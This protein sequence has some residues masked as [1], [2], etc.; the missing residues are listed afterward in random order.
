M[1]SIG[2]SNSIRENQ[3][4]LAINS[5]NLIIKREMKGCL[6]LNETKIITFITKSVIFSIKYCTFP[7][8]KYLINPNNFIKRN[9]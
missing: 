1:F 2:L 5:L 3:K 7:G 9:T 4:Y 8:Q 6:S